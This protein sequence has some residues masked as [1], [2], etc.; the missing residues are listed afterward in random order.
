LHYGNCKE[1]YIGFKSFS[2]KTGN[3]FPI[4]TFDLRSKIC[5]NNYYFVNAESFSAKTGEFGVIIAMVTL[6]VFLA[7]ASQYFLK[8]TNLFNVLRQ[9]SLIT[10]LSVG[11][12]DFG[13]QPEQKK[14]LSP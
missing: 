12:L 2:A 14:P 9:L 3:Q 13:S 1:V 6:C 8:T 4:F 5:D 10:T 7:F 11:Q